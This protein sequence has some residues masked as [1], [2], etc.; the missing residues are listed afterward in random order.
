LKRNAK[1]ETEKEKGSPTLDDKKNGQKKGPFCTPRLGGT[2]ADIVGIVKKKKGG[3]SSFIKKEKKKRNAPPP[4][5]GSIRK[6]G[7]R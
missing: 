7:G 2:L 6:R 3:K 4:P 5:I 1:K